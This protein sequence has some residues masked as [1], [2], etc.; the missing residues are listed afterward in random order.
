MPT[1]TVLAGPNG[2]GKTMLINRF[3]KLGIL[4]KTTLNLDQVP[5][6]VYDQLSDN[7]YNVERDFRKRK[8]D[9]SLINAKVPLRKRL[10]LPMNVI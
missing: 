8:H 9:F 5:E 6:E 1:L 10:I 7:V 2:A 4:P 3:K